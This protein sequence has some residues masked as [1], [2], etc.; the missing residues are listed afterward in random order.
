MRRVE[1]EECPYGATASRGCD[2]EGAEHGGGFYQ[3]FFVFVGGVGIGDD[4]AA[5]GGV[6]EAVFDEH[7]A[8]GDAEFH[9]A[10]GG[11][12]TDG[13]AIGPAAKGFKLVDDLD[14]ADFAG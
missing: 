8:N 1:C 10:I 14:G 12:I 7:G 6:D 5:N 3:G 13:S 2:A 9:R 4:T 11:E